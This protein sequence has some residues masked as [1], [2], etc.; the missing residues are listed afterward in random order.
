MFFFAFLTTVVYLL[1]FYM[2]VWFI[3][4]STSDSLFLLLLWQSLIHY[5]CGYF[6]LLLHF[7]HLFSICCQCVSINSVYWNISH[8]VTR[9][10]RVFQVGGQPKHRYERI[11]KAQPLR[12]AAEMILNYSSR[13]LFPSLNQYHQNNKGNTD[14]DITAEFIK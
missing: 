11:L 6:C 7:I 1:S 3:I 5:C 10:L 13:I 4:S 12:Y 2:Y 14:T 9:L 8:N